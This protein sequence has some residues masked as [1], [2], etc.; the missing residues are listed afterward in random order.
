MLKLLTLLI[1]VI[2]LDHGLF[3]LETIRCLVSGSYSELLLISHDFFDIYINLN[4]RQKIS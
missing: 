1:L 4:Q 3:V 2:W